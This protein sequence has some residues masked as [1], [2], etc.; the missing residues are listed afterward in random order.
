RVV[1]APRFGDIFFSNA[2]KAGLLAVRLDEDVVERLWD[3]LD[4]TPGATIAVDLER[5]TVEAGGIH[6]G[7]LLDEYTRWR[8]LHGYD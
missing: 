4:A 1:I 8:L 6:V 5:G 3:H 7:F 2:G